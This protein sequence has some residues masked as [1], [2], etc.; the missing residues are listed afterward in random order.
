M[1]SGSDLQSRVSHFTL[2]F[3]Q[4][5]ENGGTS[6][7]G[8]RTLGHLRLYALPPLS[9]SS[10]CDSTVSSLTLYLLC[11]FCFVL[12]RSICFA[13]AISEFPSIVVASLITF[14]VARSVLNLGFKTAF[15]YFSS[16]CSDR[17][18]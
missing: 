5:E 1:A 16:F 17:F 13:S 9:L 18:M 6:R 3:N 11:V 10:F 15:G 8:T 4:E 7:N 2:S 12:A 14:F